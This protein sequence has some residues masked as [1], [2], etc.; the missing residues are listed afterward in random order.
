MEFENNKRSIFFILGVALFAIA[1]VGTFVI[2]YFFFVTPIFLLVAIL[3]VW[4]SKRKTLTKIFW[5]ISPVGLL[6]L[7]LII[8]YK[9]N[10]M[11]SE[12]FFIPTDFRGKFVIYF[13]E[14][15]GTNV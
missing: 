14:S 2:P 9:L 3:F 5:T 6:F 7:L 15:C 12:T 1:V 10:K 8:S 11:E 4:V 13:E